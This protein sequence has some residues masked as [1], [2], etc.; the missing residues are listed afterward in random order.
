MQVIRIMEDAVELQEVGVVK[1]T[2]L[3]EFYRALTD[4]AGYRTPLLPAGCVHYAARGHRSVYTLEAAP[5]RRIVRYRSSEGPLQ[6]HKIA[7]PWVYLLVCFRERALDSVLVFFIRERLSKEED[8]LS[9]A[10]VPNRYQ[11]GSVCLGTFKYDV[12]TTAPSKIEELVKFYFD[13]DFTHEVLDSFNSYI[14][15]EISAK[16][17]SGETCFSGWERIKDEDLPKVGWIPHQKFSAALE[18]LLSRR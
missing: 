11:D 7:F 17:G 2:K 15:P 13:S 4:Q 16:T 5:E 10:P 9:H 8:V 18:Q 6:E 14:P 1:R 3:S 12:A